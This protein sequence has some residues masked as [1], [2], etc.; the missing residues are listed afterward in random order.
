MVQ[1]ETI[2]MTCMRLVKKN[3]AFLIIY[4]RLCLLLHAPSRPLPLS[5]SCLASCCGVG[6]HDDIGDANAQ[7]LQH[8]K[9]HLIHISG[10]NFRG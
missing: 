6:K 5:A 9:R 3:T 1:M 4:H 10:C 8:T 7:Y 2:S